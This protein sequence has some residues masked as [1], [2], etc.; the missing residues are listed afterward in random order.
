MKPFGTSRSIDKGTHNAVTLKPI[1]KQAEELSSTP[2]RCVV[3]CCVIALTGCGGGSNSSS[4]AE[5]GPHPHIE[6]VMVSPGSV[7]IVTGG[8]QSFTAQVHGSGTF[9]SSVAWAVNGVVGG[10]TTYGT[11]TS[12]GQYTAPASLPNPANV[13]VK[14]TSLQDPTKSGN[15]SAT[16]IPAVVLHSITP[17]AASAGGVL[18]LTATFNSGVIETP[19]VVFS[20]PNGTS[21]SMPLEIGTSL[22]V[23]VPFGA[24]SGP[25]YLT[26]P[27]QPGGLITI[28]EISNSVQFTRLPNLLVHAANKD[29]SSGEALQLDWRVL[30]ASTPNVVSWTADSGFINAQGVFQAPTVQSEGYSRVTGCILNTN[31]CNT[32]LLRILPFRI[33]PSNPIVKVGGKLQLNAIQ[34]NSIISPQWS[35]LTGGGSI[36]S[37]GLFTAPAGMPGAGPVTVSATVDSTIEQAFIAVSGAYAGQVN[38]VF[39]YADF[40]KNTHPEAA[41]VQ[42]V[43]VNGNRAYA[44]TIGGD[45]HMRIQTQSYEALDVYD[46][47]NPAQ[48]VWIDAVESATNDYATLFTYGNTL[49]SIDRNNLAVYSL[50]SQVPKLVQVVP[51]PQPWTW[52]QN[53]PVLYVAPLYSASITTTPVDLYDVSSGMAVHKHYELPNP[54]GTTTAV[55]YS[56]TGTGN[57]VYVPGYQSILTYDIS[58]SPP[59]LLSQVSSIS[60]EFEPSTVFDLKVV[61]NLLFEES[62]VYDISNITPVPITTLPM[63]LQMVWGLSG[64]DVL[65]TFG[66]PAQGAPGYAVVDTS[67]SSNPAIRASLMDLQSW[68]IFNPGSAAWAGNG[69]FYVADGSGGFSV[70]D[71]SVDGGPTS[72]S[73]AGIFQYIYDQAIEGQTLYAAAV[74]GSGAGGVG[75]F[76]IS[77]SPPALLGALTYPNDSSFAVQVSGSHVFLGMVDSLR[78]VDVSNPQSPSQIAR[79]AIPINALILAGNTLFAGTSDGRLIVFDVSNPSAPNQIGSI[80]MAAP[81]TMRLSGTLLLVAAGDAGLSIFD[82]SNPSAPAMLSQF[83]PSVG[84]PV[85]DVAPI[86]GS[87]IMLA[88]DLS[89]IV[90][91]DISNPSRPLQLAQ[92]PLPH[93]TAFPNN[94]SQTGTISAISLATQ[95]GLTYVGTNYGVL[96]TYDPSVPAFPRL[97]ALNVVGYAFDFL[98]VITP[99]GNNLYVSDQGYLM[100]VDNTIPQ[101]VIELYDPPAALSLATPVYASSLWSGRNQRV[102]GQRSQRKAP[103]NP[104]RA[105]PNGLFYA[106]PNLQRK[107]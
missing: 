35:I 83:S 59:Q 18:T 8:S 36:T 37:S 54:P 50:Q 40:T 22:T 17:A 32:V 82:V 20:G 61:G 10:N 84:A 9:S 1:C 62:G 91:V 34:G 79:V 21:I 13:T 25:V 2:L 102:P 33:T 101:N 68:D 12:T 98:P 19:Q 44:L 14:A 39:D 55:S 15:S 75:C 73:R 85:W 29:L 87:S 86:G 99:N 4:S 63:P 94:L 51:V 49:F 41:Y 27:P 81:N 71:V 11:I 16:I 80:A 105:R 52:S 60:T 56:I 31:A 53:G 57:A 77:Q 7:T 23:E 48:P 106:K 70:Y 3:L 100:Q 42:S 92:Q 28:S 95:D 93:V 64:N 89:G 78:V 65:A 96:L 97:V 103:V 45:P 6:S 24:T 30:G 74:Y 5:S 76:D 43:A 69:I 72:M 67:L 38:R 88:A 47:T 66:A 107:H 104:Q 26:V 58:Q 46:I 90:T